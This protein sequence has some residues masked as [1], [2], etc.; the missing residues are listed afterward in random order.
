MQIQTKSTIWNIRQ[1]SFTFHVE[2]FFSLC[3]CAVKIKMFGQTRSVQDIYREQRGSVQPSFPHPDPD[4]TAYLN[5][6]E[7]ATKTVPLTYWHV[8]IFHCGFVVKSRTNADS[9]FS[10]MT[11]N[12]R[13]GWKQSKWHFWIHTEYLKYSE[14]LVNAASS[15]CHSTLQQETETPISPVYLYHMF[16]KFGFKCPILTFNQDI[17][18]IREKQ[19]CKTHLIAPPVSADYSLY[20]G[21]NKTYQH[22]VSS[23]SC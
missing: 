17:K 19:K 15:H 4:D 22:S 6:H 20:T 2:D 23:A 9:P 10:L 12:C 14:R 11:S 7:K 5:Q 16:I 3:M 13:D 1:N 8:I 21:E 18:H